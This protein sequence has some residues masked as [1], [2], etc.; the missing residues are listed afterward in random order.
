MSRLLLVVCISFVVLIALSKVQSVEE[1]HDSTDRKNADLDIVDHLRP[2][3][4]GDY[5]MYWRPQKV[6]SSTLL[7]IL[8]SYAYRY[9]FIPRRKSYS[10]A[11][12][13]R[14]ADCALKSEMNNLSSSQKSALKKLATRT[15]KR[16]TSARFLDQARQEDHARRIPFKIILTHEMCNT[17]SDIVQRNLLCV[18]QTAWEKEPE[19]SASALVREVFQVRNPVDRAISAYYFWGELY[20][21]VKAK[22][23]KEVTTSN[24]ENNLRKR[25][26]KVRMIQSTGSK[27][28]HLM[29]SSAIVAENAIAHEDGEWDSLAFE[30]DHRMLEATLKLGSLQDTSPVE[31][32]LFHYHGNEKTVPQVSYALDYVQN[33]PYMAGMPGPSY[34]WSAFANNVKSSVNRIL[35]PDNPLLNDLPLHYPNFHTQNHTSSNVAA[36]SQGTTLPMMTIVLERMAESLVVLRHHLGWS[37]ADVIYIKQRKSLSSHPK[38]RDWPKDAVALLQNTMERN[39]EMG[40]YNASIVALNNRIRVLEQVFHV[41]ISD[42]VRQFHVLRRRVSEICLDDNHLSQYKR[43]MDSHQL[44]QHPSD[45]KLRD[46]EAK[47]VDEGHVYS[48]NREI[49]CSFDVCGAC[50]AHAM[51]L[52]W[53]QGLSADLESAPSLKDLPD[54][55]RRNNVNFVHCPTW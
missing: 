26:N 10:N 6:G 28:R 25:G 44:P 37:L 42:E 50:E 38:A 52:A 17:D 18:F 24:K 19:K 14:I 22:K 13:G 30:S 55:L 33:L 51:L 12:C 35:Y 36:L 8:M 43:M 46:V 11:S 29:E 16:P 49:L 40:V 45:N 20:K 53:Q 15:T 7:S 54:H 41:N 21:L 32:G 4:D 47:Y 9:N 48:F 1:H 39:G 5:I 34:T 27:S 31:G 2:L 23:R 3:K